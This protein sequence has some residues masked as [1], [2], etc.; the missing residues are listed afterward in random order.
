PHH[1]GRLVGAA[2]S[3]VSRPQPQVRGWQGATHPASAQGVLRKLSGPGRTLRA[4]KSSDSATKAAEAHLLVV[5]DE[6]NISELL[7]A[8]LRF[9][10]FVWTVDSDGNAANPCFT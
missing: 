1:R 4:M 5:D 8:S 3:S 2:P 9:V 6:P 7:S 10:G